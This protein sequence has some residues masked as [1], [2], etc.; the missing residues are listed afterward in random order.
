MHRL[1]NELK[2]RNVF[3]A[4]AA[5]TVMA[6]VV[7]QVAE[8]ILP[9]FEAPGWVLKVV[10]AL[11][12]LGVP[13]VMVLAWVYELTPEGLRRT[14]DDEPLVQGNRA[15]DVMM[16]VAL[17][18]A[19]G[20]MLVFPFGGWSPLLA[21]RVA[22]TPAG[23]EEGNARRIAVL[24][25]VNVSTGPDSSVLTRGLSRLLRQELGQSPGVQVLGRATSV[26]VRDHNIATTVVAQDFHVDRVVQTSMRSNNGDVVMDMQ[27]IDP[28]QDQE[29]WTATFTS[30]R[31]EVKDMLQRAISDLR[32]Q[33]NLADRPLTGAEL[34]PTAFNL[35]LNVLAT[36]DGTSTNQAREAA[37]RL[38]ELA[39]A[40]GPGR[41]ALA[42]TTMATNADN[43]SPAFDQ[44]ATKARSMLEDAMA[45]APR[46][47][48][49]VRWRAAVESRLDVWRASVADFERINELFRQGLDRFPDSPDLRAAFAKHLHR[50]GDYNAS[51]DQAR[52]V[53]EA[54]P[55]AGPVVELLIESLLA[56]GRL[57]DAQA[58]LNELP[59]LLPDSLLTKLSG[60][61]AITKGDFET[62]E[63]Y[64]R[65]IVTDV[66]ALHELVRIELSRGNTQAANNWLNML[67]ESDNDRLVWQAAIEEDAE[68]AFTAARDA[69]TSPDPS[70][71]AL[72]GRLAVQ[73]GNFQA[74]LDYF[75]MYFKSW[76]D[77]A[78]QLQGP[79]AW[80]N[81]PW[82]AY[83][84]L[85]NNETEAAHRL[86][87]RHL[88]GV[89]ASELT[90]S[91]TKSQLYLAANF[92][93]RKRNQ[94]AL[95][96]LE[97]AATGGF[98]LSWG[99]LGTPAPLS[100][101]A[102]LS[103]L[104]QNTRFSEI[105]ERLARSPLRG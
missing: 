96:A 94:D 44:A 86:L 97:R 105:I 104:P 28:H 50:W 60:R 58:A 90:L 34:D 36:I 4:T 103:E 72:L 41:A 30:N 84:L 57:N 48:Y 66:D 61:M 92:A 67:P 8:L 18:V 24:P 54:D 62:A 19:V 76:P 77:D 53:L 9:T 38:S 52:H 59:P 55:L 91:T 101:I 82:Y 63:K 80:L 11:L 100:E 73:A 70:R 47:L 65:A 21:E 45:T 1:I 25:V 31:A 89:I 78:G 81:A 2:R 51:A 10:I 39:P 33:L 40:F 79:A 75:K 64:L 43:N 17:M 98:E 23:Q 14:T 87:D 20:A 46:S 13:L 95:T 85:A 74:A 49:V 5:Y 35:W 42:M 88:A 37:I 29:V 83:A 99:A 12:M 56:A 3:R 69:D 32:E 16:I 22:T 7:G 68:T 102:L 71:A 15:V 6:W 26:A 93:V 27:L